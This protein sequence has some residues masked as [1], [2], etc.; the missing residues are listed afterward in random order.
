LKEENVVGLIKAHYERVDQTVQ[1]LKLATEA[2]E[3]G[4]REALTR[5]VKEA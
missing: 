2:L 5:A 1:Q 4:N 3:V